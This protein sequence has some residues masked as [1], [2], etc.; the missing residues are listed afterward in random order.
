MFTATL[1]VFKSIPG[2]D[3]LGYVQDKSCL[4]VATCLVHLVYLM[5][6][7]VN[8]SNMWNPE[9]RVS[10]SCADFLLHVKPGVDVGGLLS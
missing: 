2:H 9:R 3:E 1:I 5:P 6:G 8:G 4:Y 7:T 10:H